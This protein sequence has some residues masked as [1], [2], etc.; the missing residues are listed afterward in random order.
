MR[1]SIDKL[2][3]EISIDD[4]GAY[5]KPFSTEGTAN[6]LP[7]EDLLEYICNQN[8][9]DLEHIDAPAQLP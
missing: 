1:A 8:N 5:A 7:G 2:A 6:F 9:I 4:P 3:I